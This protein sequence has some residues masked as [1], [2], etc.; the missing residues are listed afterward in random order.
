MTEH[1]ANTTSGSNTGNPD[2]SDDRANVAEIE[3][4]I[5]QTRNAISGDLRTL[6]ERLDPAHLKE[7]AKE[8]IV[9]A[10]NV[11]V[12]TLHEAKDVAT[13]T[14]RE[15]KD[16]AVNAVSDKVDEIRE[17]VYA[18]ERQTLSF[19]R[20]NALPLALIGAGV[21][22]FLA[23]RRSSERRWDDYGRGDDNWRYPPRR[24]FHPLDDARSGASR[25]AGGARE[26]ASQ[27]R[28]QAGDWADSAGN[29]AGDVA[30]RVRGY[31]EREFDQVGNAARNAEQRLTETAYRARDFAGR[32]LRE[33]RD[34]SRQMTET[35]PLAVGAAAVAAGIGIGLLIPS[36]RPEQELLGP[37]RE[38]LFGDAKDAAQQIAQ[39]AKHAAREVKDT[40]SGSANG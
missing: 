16:N 25:L 26:R 22:W 40:L 11:A 4:E 7:E 19:L 24:G 14:F 17:N 37:R 27:A 6:G 33:A 29:R 18:A 35:H 31:A 32:E 30:N 20:E 38:R 5:D 28:S 36:T 10:K 13:N 2:A 15:V 9:E 34:Y 23:N 21:S 12:E 1:G 8:V 3:A 39:S